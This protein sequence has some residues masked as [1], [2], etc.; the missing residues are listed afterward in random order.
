MHIHTTRTGNRAPVPV[1][2]AELCRYVR[3]LLVLVLALGVLGMHTAPTAPGASTTHTVAHAASAHHAHGSIPGSDHTTSPGILLASHKR[4]A[5][6]WGP[7]ECTQGS[8]DTPVHAAHCI[9]APGGV[10]PAPPAVVV[11]ERSDALPQPPAAS[12]PRAI[13]PRAPAPDLAQLS[14][15]RT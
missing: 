14:I 8:G 3:W 10:P 4:L 2:G 15:S 13:L 7:D 12:V 1:P 6:S 5:G 11:L 9:P